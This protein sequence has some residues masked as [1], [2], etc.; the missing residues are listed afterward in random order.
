MSASSSLNAAIA[1]KKAA[2]QKAAEDKAAALASRL[3][4][5]KPVRPLGSG[6]RV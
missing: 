4:A 6:P 5:N 1:A 3:A 2:E